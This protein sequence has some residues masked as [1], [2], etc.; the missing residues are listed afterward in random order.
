MNILRILFVI[1][2]ANTR[3]ELKE[4]KNRKRI[5]ILQSNVEFFKNIL[6]RF[7]KKIPGNDFLRNYS[8]IFKLM[9]IVL[10]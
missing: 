6:F 5:C 1:I 3:K 10:I 4:D 9:K 2:T 8:F 7:F